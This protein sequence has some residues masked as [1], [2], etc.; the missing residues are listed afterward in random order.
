M[1]KQFDKIKTYYD[2]GLWNKARVKNMV[3]KNIITKKEYK[4]I[5]GEAY[6]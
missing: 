3:D 1:S 6:S 5:T 4:A 2:T